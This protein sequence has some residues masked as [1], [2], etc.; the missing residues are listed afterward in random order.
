MA[1]IYISLENIPT[2]IALSSDIVG[3]MLVGATALGKTVFTTNDGKW[4][5]IAG[6]S[7]S[8]G[9]LVAYKAPPLA[10]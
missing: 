5:L 10:T 1:L 8:S 4:Y 6:V 9:S 7:G 3:G 2:Y